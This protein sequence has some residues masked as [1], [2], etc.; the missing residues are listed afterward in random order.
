MAVWGPLG[1]CYKQVIAFSLKSVLGP[2]HA[3]IMPTVNPRM[4]GRLAS[5]RGRTPTGPTKLKKIS[6]G[7]RIY[8]LIGYLK[9]RYAKNQAC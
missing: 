7:G 6:G 8:F 4:R 3:R 5:Q 9:I 1:C 2:L